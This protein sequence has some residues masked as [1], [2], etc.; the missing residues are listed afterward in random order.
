[1]K[2]FTRPDAPLLLMNYLDFNGT[3]IICISNSR[4]ALK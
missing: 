4:S 1:M 3:L 2:D